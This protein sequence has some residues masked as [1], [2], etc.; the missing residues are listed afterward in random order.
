MTSF[1]D[2][3]QNI[4]TMLY[5]S[6]NNFPL[7]MAGVM[8]VIGLMTANYAFLFFLCGMLIIAP[9]IHAIASPLLEMLLSLFGIDPS[10][11]KVP[12]RDICSLVIPFTTNL[13]TNTSSTQLVNV[14]PS[15]WMSLTVFFFAY[16]LTN[17]ISIN[18]RPDENVPVVTS[19]TTKDDEEKINEQQ[20]RITTRKRL[21]MISIITS[22][23]IAVA[24]IA[25]RAMKSGCETMVGVIASLAIFAPLGYGWYAILSYAGQDRLSDLFG[26]ANRILPSSAMS[27]GPYAC[28]PSA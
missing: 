19:S 25:I 13:P 26:I 16:I 15:M 17:A 7:T 24:F 4:R 3:M 27:D 18:N 28:L 22:A 9:I 14:S 10:I 6:F 23:V 20:A 2:I 21:T 1:S 5:G 12:A 11:Y 8:L